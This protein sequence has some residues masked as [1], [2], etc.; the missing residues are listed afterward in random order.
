MEIQHLILILLLIL[1]N[2]ILALLTQKLTRLPLLLNVFLWGVISSLVIP[3]IHFDTGIRADNF[4][5]LIMY[6]L[7]PILVFEASLS[8]KLKVLKPLLTSILLS[9]SLGLL[10][11]LFIAATILFYGINHSE[12]FPWIAALLA[13]LVI[14]ATDPAAVV[15][16]L[17]VAKAPDK[18]STLIEGESLFNDATAIVLFSVLLVAAQQGTDIAIGNTSIQV[19]KVL[20]GGVLTGWIVAQFARVLLH[21]LSNQSFHFT[22]VSITLAYGSFYIAEHWLH[23]S[24][25]ISVLVSAIC[26]KPHLQR[27]K[28]LSRHVHEHWHLMTFLCN[29][30]LFYLMGLVVSLSMFTDQWLA[31]ILGV[32]AATTSRI[33]S[34]YFTLATSRVLPGQELPWN[35]APVMVWGGL[36]GAIT[37]ALVLSLPTE[38]DYWWTVQSIGFGVV[39]FTLLV[40]A[41]SLPLLLRRSR[42]KS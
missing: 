17:K 5:P 8:L 22:L 12:G 1:T 9:S 26:I 29:L 6:V 24:G 14:S 7:L 21:W 13:G 4:Q 3:L 35:Y 36:R 2:G 39:I 23:V 34:S 20:L 41:T 33:V 32:L 19:F 27:K 30:I 31:I 18:L 10:I 38:I 16:Q 25:V 28:K 37:L 15:A 42:Y 40:Q 11:A